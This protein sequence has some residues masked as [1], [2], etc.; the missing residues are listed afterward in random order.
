MREFHN[1]DLAKLHNAYG[2]AIGIL[3]LYIVVSFSGW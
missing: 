2:T 3:K 1:S